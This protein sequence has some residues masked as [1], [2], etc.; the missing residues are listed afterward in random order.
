VYT[1]SSVKQGT[2]ACVPV[3]RGR[4]LQSYRLALTCYAEV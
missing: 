3:P 4:Y 2:D 1:K